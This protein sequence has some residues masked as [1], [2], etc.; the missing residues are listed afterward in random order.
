MHNLKIYKTCL[1]W[2]NKK[3][4]VKELKLQ[5]H[6]KHLWKKSKHNPFHFEMAYFVHFPLDW[7]VFTD[8]DA[9]GGGL[10]NCLKSQK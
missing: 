10:Q 2:K 9:L 6:T 4:I 3:P 1:K 5:N 7:N 8:L